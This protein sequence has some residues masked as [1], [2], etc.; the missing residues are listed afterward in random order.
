MQQIR[1]RHRE[2]EDEGRKER[3]REENAAVVGA[4]YES[5]QVEQGKGER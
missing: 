1:T 3:R 2:R 4:A 5:E